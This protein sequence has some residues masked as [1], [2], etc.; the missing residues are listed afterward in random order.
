MAGS[1]PAVVATA[2]SRFLMEQIAA[3]DPDGVFVIGGD[4]AFAVVAELGFPPLWPIREVVP[5]VPITCIKHADL[6]RALPR[7][8][9]DLFLITKAGGFGE[10]D[11]IRRV[12]YKLN[13]NAK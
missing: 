1:D 13:H 2:N 12:Y 4:T 10:P 9:R 8:R 5:G 6:Q 3:G 11:V 7:R